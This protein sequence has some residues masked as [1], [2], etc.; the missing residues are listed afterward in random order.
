MIFSLVLSIK[1][2][3]K[4]IIFIYCGF[5][6]LFYFQLGTLLYVELLQYICFFRFKNCLKLNS[7]IFSQP[8]FFWRLI[9]YNYQ[10]NNRKQFHSE[11]VSE[12]KPTIVQYQQRQRTVNSWEKRV[13]KRC[14]FL[15][16]FV[17][18]YNFLYRF[19]SFERILWQN[20]GKQYQAR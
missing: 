17:R 18:I 12:R 11:P 16:Q 1:S 8:I 6:S 2:T 4:R 5:F 9:V 3:I 15:L 14:T 10:A 19:P 20:G 13:G 7:L